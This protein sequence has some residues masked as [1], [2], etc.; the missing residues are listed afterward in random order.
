MRPSVPFVL[1]LCLLAGA[2]CA[3]KKSTPE[4]LD[5]LK[6]SEDRDRILAV[7]TLPERKK[8]ADQVIPALV[9]ALKDKD[10]DVRTSAAIGLGSFGADAR[11]A[12]P[13]L[14]AAQRDRNAKVREAASRALA[15]I[16][17][18]LPPPPRVDIPARGRPGF[19][20]PR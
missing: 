14:Q 12:I 19:R 5:D 2:G 18:S 7:R 15:R 10:E 6:S 13:A 9:E 3:R 20:G 11:D 1:L 17:P 4:L 8:D 16:D